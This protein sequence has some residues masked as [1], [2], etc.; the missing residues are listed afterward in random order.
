MYFEIYEDKAGEWRRR[1]LAK[2]HRTMADSGE[3][4]TRKSDVKRA[5]K[6]FVYTATIKSVVRVMI[7]TLGQDDDRYVWCH[8]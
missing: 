2:N 1:F 3:G 4:Y 5:I 6:R 8:V 7:S